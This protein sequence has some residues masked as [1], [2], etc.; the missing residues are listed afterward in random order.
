MKPSRLIALFPLLILVLLAGCSHC[1]R[2]TD[3]LYQAS[4]I[5]A[6]LVGIYD[7]TT[8]FAELKRHGNFG[9][10]TFDSLDGEM[11]AIDGTF[12]QAKADGTVFPVDDSA[13][14][15]FA[16]VKFFSPGTKLPLSGSRDLNSL[17]ME[18]DTMLPTHN[19]FY[20]IRIEGTFPAIKVRSVPAQQKPYPGLAEAASKQS[21]FQ[22]STITGTIVGFRTPNFA[23]GVNLPGYHFHFISADRKVG[24]HLLDCRID[25]ADLYLDRALELHIALPENAEFAQG[26]L[27]QDHGQDLE[28]A[29][30]GPSRD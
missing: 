24:G 16:V 2:R 18:L 3:T 6:L 15:P 13:K 30:R 25:D 4:T 17:M 10:G 29:E 12:Y 7:G 22:F 19:Y 23:R 14:T 8:T 28:K 26:N 5:D 27:G 9:I 20:A 1:G 11:I 21:V